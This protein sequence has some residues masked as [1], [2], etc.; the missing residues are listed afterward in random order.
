MKKAIVFF[1]LLLFGTY[2][3]AVASTHDNV[4]RMG[5][6]IFYK[7]DI[8]SASNTSVKNILREYKIDSLIID[9]EGG[10][11]GY[12]IELG[13]L[14]YNHH[15]DVKVENLCVSSCANY[16]FTAGKRKILEPGSLVVWHGSV[17]Q[18]DFNT[19]DFSEIEKEVG[20]EMNSGE[21]EA[22]SKKYFNA[23]NIIK[24]RQRDFFKKIATSQEVTIIGQEMNCHCL[25]TLMP[26]DMAKFGIKNVIYPSGYLP[27]IKDKDVKILH[28]PHIRHF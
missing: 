19:I 23:L 13:N 5:N 9:S 2:N 4:W 28:P 21:R 22:F 17:I 16:V 15:L 26:S 1:L 12:G 25:W 10:N 6:A 7:G 3:H 20:H 11:V 8:T 18:K 27:Q 24:K 14:V